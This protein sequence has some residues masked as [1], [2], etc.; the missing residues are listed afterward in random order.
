MSY[1]HHFTVS[2]TINFMAGFS[3]TGQQLAKD[4][5][6]QAKA[7]NLLL[8]LNFIVLNSKNERPIL[9]KD[10]IGLSGRTIYLY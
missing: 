5:E 1:S 6:V 4:W 9:I 2:Y 3:S 7:F 10:V 8:L